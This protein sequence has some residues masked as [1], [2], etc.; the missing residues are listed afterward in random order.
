MESIHFA[1]DFVSFFFAFALD[2]ALQLVLLSNK[3]V[4][5]CCRQTNF[6]NKT[7]NRES[8]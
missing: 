8:R 6:C 5:C 1:D 3:D 7:Y 4:S 2:L